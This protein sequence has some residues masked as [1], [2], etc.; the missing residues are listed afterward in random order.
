M[1]PIAVSFKTAAPLAR[2]RFPDMNHALGIRVGNPLSILA[3]RQRRKERFDSGYHSHDLSR[4]GV[5][6]IDLVPDHAGNPLAVGTEYHCSFRTGTLRKYLEYL[7]SRDIPQ[8]DFAT[9][10]TALA[11]KAG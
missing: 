8:A 7:S 9:V 6:D 1:H 5:P 2:G 10:Q 11:G 3:N 4:C